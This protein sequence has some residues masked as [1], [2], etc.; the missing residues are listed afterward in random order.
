MFGNR[1][2]LVSHAKRNK[3][4]IPPSLER[5]SKSN[6]QQKESKSTSTQIIQV[7]GPLKIINVGMPAACDSVSTQTVISGVN[8]SMQCM[9]SLNA[10]SQ[11]MTTECQ[12]DFVTHNS[13]RSECSTQTHDGLFMAEHVVGD[14]SLSGS[15]G[16]QSGDEWRNGPMPH[17][18]MGV[19]SL[20]SDWCGDSDS[21]DEPDSCLEDL[22]L[23]S[24]GSQTDI[25]LPHL[26]SDDL[27]PFCPESVQAVSTQTDTLVESAYYSEMRCQMA[28]TSNVS[29]QTISE[30]LATLEDSN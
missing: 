3:H 16:F 28:G 22:L 29:T 6:N 27:Q 13:V 19:Q 2:A 14:G 24:V 25:S 5:K 7:S 30:I 21:I 8:D 17:I 10:A 26:F 11:T 18:D 4:Q 12:T 1:S 20:T 23:S 9:R 15:L